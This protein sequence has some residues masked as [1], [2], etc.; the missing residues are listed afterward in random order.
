MKLW[1][2]CSWFDERPE[3]LTEMVQSLAGLCDG[4]IAVDGPYPLYPHDQAVSPTEQHAALAVACAD[5]GMEC[6]IYTP[7]PLTEVDKRAFMFRA[8]LSLA[9]PYEDWFLIIDGDTV[10]GQCAEEL[11][12]AL[13]RTAVSV[14]EVTMRTLAPPPG[15]DTAD[16][17]FRSLFRA[18]P[19]L[20]VEATHYLFVVP[21][22]RGRRYLWHTPDGHISDEPALGLGEHLRLDHRRWDRD[23]ERNDAAKAYYAQRESLRVEVPP[24]EW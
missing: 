7:G 21:T 15:H 12:E 4:L 14:G 8:A 24:A 18:L 9:T 22:E 1:A 11:R 6:H 16:Q 5:A 13:E 17:F 2:L 10:V 19:G 20:T 3:H 23:P